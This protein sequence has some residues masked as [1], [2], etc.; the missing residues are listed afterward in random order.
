MFSIKK[1]IGVMLAGTILA[2]SASSINADSKKPRKTVFM[3]LE[4]ILTWP[5]ME[6][7]PI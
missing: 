7:K 4:T 3:P 2:F 1:T 5:S 6:K